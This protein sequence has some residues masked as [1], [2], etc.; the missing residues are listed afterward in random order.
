MIKNNSAITNNSVPHCYK[1]VVSQMPPA[2][3]RSMSNQLGRAGIDFAK[4]CRRRGLDLPTYLKN[5]IG[6]PRPLHESFEHCIFE[7]TRENPRQW[8]EL[9]GALRLAAYGVLGLATLTAPTA[10]EILTL[11]TRFRG[12]PFSLADLDRVVID[13]EEGVRWDLRQ[14]PGEFRDF[15]LVRDI[16]ANLV[17]MNDVW[18]GNFPVTGLTLA[19][20]YTHLA[21]TLEQLGIPIS[22]SDLGTC[23]LWKS[24]SS[25]QP[26]PYGDNDLHQF[27]VVQC[28]EISARSSFEDPFL[29][30]V[31]R[32]IEATLAVKPEEVSLEQTAKTL[33]VSVR[34]LQRRL[35][36]RDMSFREISDMTRQKL[37]ELFLR[38]GSIPIADIS[39]RLGYSEPAGFYHAFHRWLGVSPNEYRRDVM[40]PTS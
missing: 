6:I 32:V 29:D 13:D 28:E 1:S 8:L 26:L 35:G 3:L 39:Y 14:V 17:A 11:T 15:T 22:I 37:A 20:E 31:S 18:A 40:V 21:K 7:L 5:S 23:M 25:R 24:E 2:F 4:E 38:D 34:T 30:R 12:L 27:Y 16:A 9:G 36:D 19:P 33:G 10:Q